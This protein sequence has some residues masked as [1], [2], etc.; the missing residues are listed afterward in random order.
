MNRDFVLITAP[1]QRRDGIH[2]PRLGV[3]VSRKIGGAVQRNYVKRRIREWFRQARPGLPDLD[4]VV[5][6]RRGCAQRS[7]CEI[8]ESLESLSRRGRGRR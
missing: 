1:S 3:T 7:G 6:G 2:G 8:A 4:L 5:I